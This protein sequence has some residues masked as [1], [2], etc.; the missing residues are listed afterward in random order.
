MDVFIR[1]RHAVIEDAR[2]SVSEDPEIAS[3]EAESTLNLLVG[4][5]LHGEGW[6]WKDVLEEANLGDLTSRDSLSNWLNEVIP[7]L[8]S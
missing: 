3:Q 4:K 5:H 1:A 2:I 7:V 8:E 6:A